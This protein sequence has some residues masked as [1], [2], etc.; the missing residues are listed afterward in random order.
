VLKERRVEK[1]LRHREKTLY[2]YDLAVP[3]DVEPS[4]WK[5]GKI[6]LKNMDNMDAVI[7]ERN[8]RVSNYVYKAEALVE[9]KLNDTWRWED[10][11]KDRYAIQ[12]A[13]A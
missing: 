12:P 5:A 4:I 1:V 9:E 6:Y 3:R 2:I 13:G 11:Y 10:A 7:R 8:A